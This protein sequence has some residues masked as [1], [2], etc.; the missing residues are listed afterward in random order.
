[1]VFGI[2]GIGF[3]LLAAVY[4]LALVMPVWLAALLVGT[5]LTIVALTLMSLGGKKLK[6]INPTP[7]KTIQSL[8]ENVQ[9]ATHRIK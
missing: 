1:M 9:W 7:D 2:Y 6:H 8:E 5:S 3:L 4:G